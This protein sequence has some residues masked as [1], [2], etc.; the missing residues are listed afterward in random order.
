MLLLSCDLE[1]ISKLFFIANYGDPFC[2]YVEHRGDS[3]PMYGD[4]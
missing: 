3:C 4:A 2:N 1:I